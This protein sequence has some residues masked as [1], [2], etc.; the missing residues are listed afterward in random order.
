MENKKYYIVVT[1][2][3]DT[4][5]YWVATPEEIHK[6]IDDPEVVSYQVYLNITELFI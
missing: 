4:A 2:E 6:I 1:T 3:N 5:E